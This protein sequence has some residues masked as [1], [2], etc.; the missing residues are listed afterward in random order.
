MTPALLRRTGRLLLDAVLPPRCLGCGCVVAEPA[1]LCAACWSG[2][3]FLSDPQCRACGLPFDY[4]RGEAALCGACLRRPPP[5]ERARAALA[6]DEASRGMILRFKHADR[7]DAAPAFAG[8]MGRAGAALLAE[9]DL[10]V[11]VPLHRLR[12]FTRR[13]N[14]SALLAQALGRAGGIEVL[15]DLL[16]R[17]RRTPSQG[18]LSVLQRRRNVAGAFAL[19][20]RHTALL[21]GRRVLLVDD[22]LTSGATAAACAKVL[23]RGGA[24]RVELLTLARVLRPA[25]D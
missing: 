3:R 17:R 2:L 6:Y 22:V 23:L 1:T 21:P 20:S 12:L 25:P 5:W 13:Y 11:P 24:A 19:H 14:Q 18:R 16:L 7:T 4:D 15:P 9:S 10:I 8:W